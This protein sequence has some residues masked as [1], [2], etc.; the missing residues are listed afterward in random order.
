VAQHRAAMT[1][2]FVGALIIA[3]IFTLSGSRRP[4]A[5]NGV[6]SPPVFLRRIYTSPVHHGAIAGVRLSSGSHHAHTS[7][8]LVDG[9]RDPAQCGR[10]DDADRIGRW[11]RHDCNRQRE[12]PDFD[13]RRQIDG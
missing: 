9:D 6:S 10:A 8:L 2:L 1:W 4:R 11:K 5:S 3:G 13:R 12:R 7:V